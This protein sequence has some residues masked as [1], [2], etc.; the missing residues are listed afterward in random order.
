MTTHSN[1]HWRRGTK[2]AKGADKMPLEEAGRGCGGITRR[3]FIQS[4]LM[5]GAF[6]LLPSA[7]R[8]QTPVTAAK[9]GLVFA[10]GNAW[11]WPASFSKYAAR[12]SFADIA[13]ANRRVK[14]R[15]YPIQLRAK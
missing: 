15:R 7:A 10:P 13:E 14:G 8:A 12:V 4:G 9:P 11:P 3:R 2:E 6:F 1:S 5:A